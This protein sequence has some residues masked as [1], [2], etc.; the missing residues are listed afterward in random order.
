[1]KTYQ[2]KDI[3]PVYRVDLSK[4]QKKAINEWV[5]DSTYINAAARYG[6]NADEFKR[7]PEKFDEA[8]QQKIILE[9]LI[10]EE[11][12][13]Q[14]YEVF[15]GLK[16]YDIIRTKKTLE[17][18]KITNKATELFDDGFNAVSFNEDT[19]LIYAT[20]DENGE[21]WMYSANLNEGYP[22]LFIGNEN[23]QYLGY[24]K[25]GEILT[26]RKT[27]FT[28]IGDEIMNVQDAT[29][30]IKRLHLVYIEYQG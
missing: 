14:S 19:P 30:T 9:R 21:I 1:M 12:L 29:G 6:H 25:E 11:S 20:P 2:T 27:K 7:H 15:R 23:P 16:E 24:R 22:A 17:E 28:I 10:S 3:P 26:N 5:K 8:N 4:T 18:I 13:K